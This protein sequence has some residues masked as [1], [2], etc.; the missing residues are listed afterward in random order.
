M[1]TKARLVISLTDGYLLKNT[2]GALYVMQTGG[3]RGVEEV[4]DPGTDFGIGGTPL[5]T[6]TRKRNR[7]HIRSTFTSCLVFRHE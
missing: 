4:G 1:S 6:P 2:T 5:A 3:Q 7:D